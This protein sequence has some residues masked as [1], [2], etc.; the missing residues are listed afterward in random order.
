[1]VTIYDIA[2]KVG[3]AS[4]TVSKALNDSK[5]VSDKKKFEILRTAKE[6]GYVPNASAR[7]L[8]TKRSWS[9]GVL[10]SEDLNIGLEHHFFSG[11]LQSF[12]AYVENL[13]YEVTFLSSKVGKQ[14]LTYLEW[15]KYK[16]IDGVVILTVDV[17]DVNLKELTTSG[18]PIVSVD[19]GLLN[20]PTV[21][22]DNYQGSRMAVEYLMI[23]GFRR[24]A[25]IAGPLRSFAAVERLD[26]YKEVLKEHDIK[27][28]SKLVVEANNYNYQSGIDSMDLLIQ[29]NEEVPKAIYAASDDIALGA[30]KSLRNHGYHV[31]NDVSVIGFD[32]IELS[33]HTNPSLTTISQQKEMIGEEV[34]KLLISLINHEVVMDEDNIL[35]V[36]VELIIRESTR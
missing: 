21:I 5:E 1:M 25:H 28:D 14:E 19:N 2:K 12:K 26:A 32:N 34:A 8:A 18:I 15:C 16:N 4:S 22:S 17:N 33:R 31:P 7:K 23:K 13:G 36:P 10:F 9:I 24:I 35:R 20:I 11:V 3:C 6:M 27:W 30:I 29:Q